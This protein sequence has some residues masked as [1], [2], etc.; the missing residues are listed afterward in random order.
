MDSESAKDVGKQPTEAESFVKR[1]I[2]E[3]RGDSD[4][5]DGL[6]DL[7]NEHRSGS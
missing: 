2:R 1:W 4:L 7:I 3:T 5:N 6:L